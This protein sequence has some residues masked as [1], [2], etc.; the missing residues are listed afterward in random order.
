M[1]RNPR[2]VLP[3]VAY[4]VTQRGVNRGDVFFS[5]ADRRTYLDLVEANRREAQVRVL[6]WCLM[7]NHVHWLVVPERE[8]SLA[9][10]FRRV[11]GRYAQYLNA[12]RKRSGH[13]WQ[14]RFFSC[15][16]A[17]EREDLVLRYLAWNPV[18]AALVE[19]P[20]DWRW[21]SARAFLQGP[22]VEEVALLDWDYWHGHG[23]AEWWSETLAAPED[24]RHAQA[25]RRA[26]YSGAPLG[27]VEFVKEM[28]EAFG[29]QWRQRGRPS[30]PVRKQETGTEQSASFSAA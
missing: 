29:R 27:P 17:A 7:T 10:L 11:H 16:V 30:K 13:L 28:E 26:T 12:R 9:V 4:H 1:P 2:C 3:G 15:P 5:Q 20:E 21:S 8:D 22:S 18:R 19:Q 14:N 6:G 25:L 23:A 24:V